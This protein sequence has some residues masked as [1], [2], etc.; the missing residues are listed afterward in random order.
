VY[1][2]PEARLDETFAVLRRC[3]EG[4][5][6]CLVLW[7][8]PW[9]CPEKVDAVVHPRHRAWTDGV[10][11]NGQWITEFWNHLAREGLGVRVQVHTH[12]RGAFHSP[13]DDGWPIVN[14]PGFLSL[15][16]PRF[17]LGAIGFDGAYLAEL[18]VNGEWASVAVHERIVL[19]S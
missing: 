12:R 1:R 18:G 19:T 6:E 10:E 3:G 7:V 8:S 16:L 13:T 4:R 15:V 17:A 2:L 5:R 11:V 9:A 14:S